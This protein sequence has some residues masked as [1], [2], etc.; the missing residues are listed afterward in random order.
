MAFNPSKLTPPKPKDESEDWMTTFADMTTL[1]LAFFV[2]LAS[3]SKVDVVLFEQ[4]K[5]GMAEGI[6]RRKVE[7]P[8]ES[9]KE[10]VAE[11]VKSLKVEDKVG[12]GTDNQG[13]TL[14]FAAGSFFAPGSAQFNEEAEPILSKLAATIGADRYTG[15]QIEVQ[16]HTDDTPINTPQF[17]SNWELSAAR[18]SSVIRYFLE[19]GIDPA[20][21]KA[22]GFADTSPKVPNRG[23]T[24]EPIEANQEINRRVVVRI[25]PR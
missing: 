14:E 11:V 19:V 4:V 22:I 23:P 5:A 7:T 15:F 20:R 13:V 21:M 8:V 6:G 16:G 1:L 25:Y 3:I 17:P 10:D 9:L 12:I 2:L 18:A 24:G